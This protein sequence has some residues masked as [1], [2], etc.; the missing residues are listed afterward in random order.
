MEETI[1]ERRGASRFPLRVPVSVQYGPKGAKLNRLAAETRD[2]SSSGIC[3]YVNAPIEPGSDVEFTLTMR[4]EVTRTEDIRVRCRAKG[5]RVQ[6]S[7][8]DQRIVVA[9]RIESYQFLNTI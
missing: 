9:V 7:S 3:F 8:E 6:A 2:I 4:R 1:Y 5:V